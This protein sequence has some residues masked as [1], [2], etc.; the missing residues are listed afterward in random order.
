MTLPHVS[1]FSTAKSMV[2]NQRKLDWLIDGVLER[3]VLGMLFGDPGAG[4]SFLA[5]A[6]S[7]AIAGGQNWLGRAVQRGSVV[8]VAGEGRGGI[9]RR[10]EAWAKHNG[11]SLEDL[12][13]YISDYAFNFL[14]DEENDD[15]WRYLRLVPPPIALIVV[16]TLA[17]ATPGMNED[18]ANEMAAF[19]ARCDDLKDTWGATVLV[20]HHSPHGDKT[21]AKGSIALKGAVDFEAALMRT[22]DD[23]VV[24][25]VSTKVKDGEPFADIFLRFQSVDLGDGATSAVL[26]ESEAPSNRS[27]S[28]RKI[29][30]TPNDKLFML[31]LGTEPVDEA[32][33]RTG[34]LERFKGTRET[35]TKRYRSVRKR[36]AERGWF[37][38][39]AGR[40]FP[41][42]EGIL[43]DKTDGQDGHG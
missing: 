23:D 30:L 15:L 7:C 38:E 11:A 25:L 41:A 37:T 36:A 8:Y 21:R 12:P 18:R 27:A 24:K 28:G 20:L 13:L 10:L 31:V 35:A 4:K 1:G 32:T 5:L 29:R 14:D 40:L 17:R 39:D 19:V 6:W 2:S 22:S 16:D 9:G 34:F 43:A 3:G 42:T 33:V 26:S